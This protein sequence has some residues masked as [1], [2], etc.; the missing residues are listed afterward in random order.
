[1]LKLQYFAEKCRAMFAVKAEL[2][3]LEM[4]D[5]SK[6]CPKKSRNFQERF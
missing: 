2:V 3:L 1:M 4:I 5:I 6:F